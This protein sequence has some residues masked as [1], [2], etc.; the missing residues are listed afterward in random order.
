MLYLI[1]CQVEFYYLNLRIMLDI[2]HGKYDIFIGGPVMAIV[3]PSPLVGS[4]SG[5]VGK[6]TTF[7]RYQAGVNIAKN[8][9]KPTDYNSA[10]QSAWRTG[11]QNIANSWKLL[12]PAQQAAWTN[13]SLLSTAYGVR[14]IGGVRNLAKLAKPTKTGY[15]AYLKTN[16]FLQSA[17]FPIISTPP[18]TN[19]AV[20]T[21]DPTFNYNAYTGVV[22]VFFGPA[23]PSDN[24]EVILF[25]YDLSGYFHKQIAGKTAWKNGQ[26][27]FSQLNTKTGTLKPLSPPFHFYAQLYAVDAQGHTSAPG[28]TFDIYSTTTQQPITEVDVSGDST[29][30]V[31][32]VSLPYTAVSKDK[33]GNIIADTYNWSIIPGTGTAHWFPGDKIIG[34]TIGTVTVRATSVN[35][36]AIYGDKVVTIWAYFLAFHVQP[37]NTAWGA[38]ITPSPTVYCYKDDGTTQTLQP[39]VTVTIT[40]VPGWFLDG[41]STLTAVSDITGIATFTNLKLITF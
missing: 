26:I 23:R 40:P 24:N 36:P 31:G 11:F 3:Q 34:D 29:N 9:K 14:L 13:I 10:R 35:N 7:V 19:T 28:N 30:Q 33:N 12:S 25:I 16:L 41:T 17:G 6:A 38:V 2:F 5:T 1:G 32:S 27:S 18:T 15:Q 20:L 4:I 22:T 37:S 21:P 39:G 8:Y